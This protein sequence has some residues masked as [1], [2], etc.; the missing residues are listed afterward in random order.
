MM[1]PVRYLLSVLLLNLLAS[2]MPVM[3]S[4]LIMVRTQQDFPEA[5]LTLQASIVEH[6]YAITRVQR[7]DIGLTG[8]GYET[9]KYRVVFFGKINEIHWL[10]DKFPELIP[11]LPLKIAI[12]AE[13]EET[14]LTAMSPHFLEHAYTE[15]D[16]QL[17]QI[18][19]RWDKDIRIIIENISQSN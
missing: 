3:A 1:K 15:N 6:G 5:M 7:I 2:S 16:P 19:Q 8:M 11:Y 17:L 13:G 4:D 18:F 9:D 14:I 12:F 10:R